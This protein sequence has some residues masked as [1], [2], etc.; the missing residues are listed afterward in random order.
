ME[1]EALYKGTLKSHQTLTNSQYEWS[2]TINQNTKYTLKSVKLST[3]VII[4]V[5][6]LRPFLMAVLAILGHF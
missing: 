3:R 6:L 2:K 5:H 4:L 1:V